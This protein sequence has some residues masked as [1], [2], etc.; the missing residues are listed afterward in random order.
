MSDYEKFDAEEAEY[1][2]TSKV[3]LSLVIT[4]VVYLALAL[5]VAFL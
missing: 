5:C 3:G 4:S 2:E 1:Q